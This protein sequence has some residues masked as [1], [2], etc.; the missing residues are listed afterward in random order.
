MNNFF[1]VFKKSVIFIG[2]FYLFLC[3]IY[4]IGS[5]IQE[6]IA[7]GRIL[8][9]ILILLF[10]FLSIPAGL[11]EGIEKIVGFHIFHAQRFTDVDSIA[12]CILIYAFNL[13]FAFILAMLFSIAYIAVLKF[14][15][16]EGKEEY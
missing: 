14:S 8:G 12:A 10:F 15:K 2:T 11:L 7:P 5:M 9:T 6:F 3:T 16:S 13:V 4:A 1:K